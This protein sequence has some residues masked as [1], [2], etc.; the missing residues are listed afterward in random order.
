MR[1]DAFRIHKLNNDRCL[2]ILH[3]IK[4]IVDGIPPVF[5]IL[6]CNYIKNMAKIDGITPSI[7]WVDFYKR[8]IGGLLRRSRF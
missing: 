6:R 1:S 7:K 5:L 4:E 3:R 2:E 8:S